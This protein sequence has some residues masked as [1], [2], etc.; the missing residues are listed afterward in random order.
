MVTVF[1]DNKEIPVNM[2]EFSDGALTFKL[3]E[4][5]D[6]PRYIS[7]NVCPTTPVY[8]VLEELNTLIGC[9]GELDLHLGGTNYYLNLP[10]LPYGRADRV[11]EKGNPNSLKMFLLSLNEL[12][13]FDEINVCDI[14]NKSSVDDICD[15]YE[16][17]LNIVEKSQ[18]ECFKSSVTHDFNTKYDMVLAPDKGAVT[19]AQTIADHLGTPVYNCGKERDISTGKVIKTLLPDVDFTGKVVL[20]PDDLMDGGFTFYALAKLLKDAGAKQVDL[21]V[22][23]MIGA[24]GLDSL[25]GLIDNVYC[26][27]TVGGY[28][29]KQDV[30]NFNLNK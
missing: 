7:V 10:Y 11:F 14:H 28:L 18:L 25:K 16:L 22:T 6:N 4:L 1:A 9:F 12:G 27:N 19:K 15:E 30:T 5:P 13:W 3:D 29:T 24:K 8:R 23:H 26:Y 17:N 21:Y 20:I 2:V